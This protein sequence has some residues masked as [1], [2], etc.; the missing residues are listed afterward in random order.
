MKRKN[1]RKMP[2]LFFYCIAKNHKLYYNYIN[3]IFIFV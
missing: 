3:E 1:P 2:K